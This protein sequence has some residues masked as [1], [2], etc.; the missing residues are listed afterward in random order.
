MALSIPYDVVMVTND[1]TNAEENWRRL[2]AFVPGAR[3]V[4]GA[5]SIGAAYA[6]A[7]VAA[8]TPHFFAIDGDSWILDGFDFAVD[9]PPAPDETLVWLARNPVNGL[10]Y[11][12]GAI[13][14]LPTERMRA[15][16]GTSAIDVTSASGR[17]RY[18]RVE[19]SEHRFNASP[20]E[21]WRAAFRECVKIAGSPTDGDLGERI[22]MLLRTWCE[23]GAEA[24]FGRWTMEG[25][26]AGR[27]YAM[28]CR[29]GKEPYARINDFAW[30]RETFE[31]SYRLTGA[32]E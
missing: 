13:K 32:S 5:T 21:A 15:M 10:V 16:Q 23:I 20:F 9:T 4:R 6:A 24:P 26:R 31:S 19:A 2:L 17:L 11:S 18:I 27:R 22:A 1:E 29:Q 7:A 14:L 30:L 25:A 8:V 3:R 28:L 12:H